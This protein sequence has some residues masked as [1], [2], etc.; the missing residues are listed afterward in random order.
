[1]SKKNETFGISGWIML[2]IVLVGSIIVVTMLFFNPKKNPPMITEII[3]DEKQY[4]KYNSYVESIIEDEFK[5]YLPQ[6]N[7]KIIDYCYDYCCTPYEEPRFCILIKT[8][9]STANHIIKK[10]DKFSS[11]EENDYYVILG[12]DMLNIYTDEESIQN[13]NINLLIVKVSHEKDIV[14]YTVVHQLSNEYKYEAVLDIVNALKTTKELIFPDAM[15]T[16]SLTL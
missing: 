4:G 6:K 3:T 1:M 11:D 13:V 7:S 15:G 9:D 14:E 12:Q 2:A 5:A 8:E 10:F 16:G